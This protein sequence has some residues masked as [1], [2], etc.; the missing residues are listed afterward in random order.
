MVNLMSE[1]EKQFSGLILSVMTNFYIIKSRIIL[2]NKRQFR[3]LSGGLVSVPFTSN[4][5]IYL[6]ISLLFSHRHIIPSRL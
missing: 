1:R 6:Q 5:E 4:L 2:S 3:S